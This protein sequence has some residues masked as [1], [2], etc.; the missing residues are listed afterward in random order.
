MAVVST[1]RDNH[2]QSTNEMASNVEALQIGALAPAR[3]DEVEEARMYCKLVSA[4]SARER[5]ITGSG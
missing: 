2:T 1:R 3:R 5:D 4:T